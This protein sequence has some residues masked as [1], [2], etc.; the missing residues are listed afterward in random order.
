M[1]RGVSSDRGSPNNDRPGIVARERLCRGQTGRDLTDILDQRGLSRAGRA[2]KPDLLRLF[3]RREQNC[4][5]VD[6]FAAAHLGEV[7]SKIADLSRLAADC[8][9]EQLLRGRGPH[10]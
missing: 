8:V 2:G 3:A 9:V 1:L 7:E 6:I 10:R 5:D 4:S